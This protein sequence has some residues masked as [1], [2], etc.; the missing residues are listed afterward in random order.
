MP[1]SRSMKDA[2]R[3]QRHRDESARTTHIKRKLGI[4]AHHD[5]RR[6]GPPGTTAGGEPILGAD[7]FRTQAVEVDKINRGG[8]NAAQPTRRLKKR[9]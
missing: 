5:P 1:K 9:K 8:P 7:D 6:Y 2:M 3:P 4:G